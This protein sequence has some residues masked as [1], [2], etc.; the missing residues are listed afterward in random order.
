M[1][2]FSRHYVLLALLLLQTGRTQLRRVGSPLTRAGAEGVTSETI[3]CD[4]LRHI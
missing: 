1:A 3:G 2:C 4:P